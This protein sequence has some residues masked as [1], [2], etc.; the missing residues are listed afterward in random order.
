MGITEPGTRTLK[1]LLPALKSFPGG[2]KIFTAALPDFLLKRA[3]FL[4]PA[5]ILLPAVLSGNF[6]PLPSFLPS[7][8]PTDFPVSKVRHT[9]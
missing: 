3:T 6:T 5:A 4:P 7:L 1:N 9:H 8:A 2:L